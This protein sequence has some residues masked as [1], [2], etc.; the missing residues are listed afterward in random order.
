M[1]RAG[2]RSC[3]LGSERNPDGLGSRGFQERAIGDVRKVEPV[4]RLTDPGAL[5]V[6]HRDFLNALAGLRVRAEVPER[7]DVVVVAG[8]HDRG[9]VRLVRTQDVDHAGGQIR[10]QRDRDHV[11]RGQGRA[12]REHHDRVALSDRGCHRTHEAE[13]RQIVVRLHADR[14]DRLVQ[15]GDEH[16]SRHAADRSGVAIRVGGPPEQRLDRRVELLA[17]LTA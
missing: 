13:Q 15:R 17:C 16:G 4:E 3:L 8:E 2:E 10:A 11:E 14:A 1:N 5:E 12:T 9:L 6:A 7:L